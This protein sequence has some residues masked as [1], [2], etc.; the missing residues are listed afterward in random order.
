MTLVCVALLAVALLFA[1][2]LFVA[3]LFMALLF[4]ETTIR[5]PGR[6]DDWPDGQAVKESGHE[7]CRP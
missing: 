7:K 1:A 3:L 2:L 6:R 4:M 5:A